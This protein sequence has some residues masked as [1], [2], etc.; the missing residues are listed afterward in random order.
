MT[1][2]LQGGLEAEGSSAGAKGPRRARV[3]ASPWGLEVT[4]PEAAECLPGLWK[5]GRC[6]RRA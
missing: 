5:R 3:G 6:G 1:A 2:G 4:G